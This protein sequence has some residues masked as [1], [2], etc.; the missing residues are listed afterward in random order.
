MSTPANAE[1]FRR[2]GNHY[3]LTVHPPNAA[4]WVTANTM[5]LY[6]N[7]IFVGWFT[8]AD[9]ERAVFFYEMGQC[10]LSQLL[11]GR[12]CLCKMSQEGT[13]WEL[14]LAIADAEGYVWEHGAPT[15]AWAREHLRCTADGFQ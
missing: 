4:P 9:R 2:L 13:A 8:D 3:G 7:D 15:L 12:S 10:Y 5:A 1:L 14:G 6:G 11:R